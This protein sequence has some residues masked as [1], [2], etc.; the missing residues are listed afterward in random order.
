MDE[1]MWYTLLGA[2]QESV[3][4]MVATGGIYLHV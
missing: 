4:I 1:G 2:L 3:D